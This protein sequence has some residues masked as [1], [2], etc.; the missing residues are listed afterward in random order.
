M[1]LKF[2]ESS[3]V[4]LETQRSSSGFWHAGNMQVLGSIFGEDFKADRALVPVLALAVRDAAGDPAVDV[5]VHHG[6]AGLQ[7]SGLS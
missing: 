6:S 1:Y 2:W 7:V 5:S 4:K 3:G